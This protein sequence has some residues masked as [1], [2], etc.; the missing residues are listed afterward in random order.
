[1][2]MLGGGSSCCGV[3]V[4]RGGCC[5]RGGLGGGGGGEG[6]QDGERGELCNH[7]GFSLGLFGGCEVNYWLKVFEVVDG[8]R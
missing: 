4:V 2:G 8:F 1:L 3:G 5:L 6:G 7:C